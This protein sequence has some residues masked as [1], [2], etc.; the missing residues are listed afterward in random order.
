VLARAGE[1]ARLRARKDER[2]RGARAWSR[3]GEARGERAGQAGSGVA[4][5][6]ARARTS[7]ILVPRRSTIWSVALAGSVCSTS[8]AN[9]SDVICS[10]NWYLNALRRVGRARGRARV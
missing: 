5:T 9:V 6:R 8:R 7:A 4:R 2:V 10:E 1:R 3:D